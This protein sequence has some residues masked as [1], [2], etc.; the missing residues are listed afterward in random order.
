MKTTIVLRDVA[1]CRSI[2]IHQR[3]EG[4]HRL[5]LHGRMARQPVSS[6]TQAVRTASLGPSSC[7][8]CHTSV[9]FLPDCTASQPSSRNCENL[10]PSKK[11]LNRAGR[12][13]GNALDSCSAGP[14]FQSWRYTGYHGLRLCDFPQF[15]R[16]SIRSR[17]VSSKFF[18]NH[19]NIR[20]YMLYRLTVS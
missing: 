15:L 6:K 14:R 7:S 17:Q 12:R 8:S 20:R 10:K 9:Y 13:S 1:P 19:P 11:H 4:T 16:A 18:P 3:F 2:E 5:H